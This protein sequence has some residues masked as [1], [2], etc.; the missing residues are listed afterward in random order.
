[1]H[2]N[3]DS[4]GFMCCCWNS[5][6]Q[7]LITHGCGALT[8]ISDPCWSLEEYVDSVRLRLNCAGLCEPVPCAA[9]QPRS[10]DTG[11]AHATCCALGE[12]TRGH[13]A[14]TAQEHA[15]AQS[16]DCTS[17]FFVPGLNLGT[18][19][20][21]ADVFTS[22][23]GNSYTALDISIC[24]QHAQQAG[25]DSSQSRL[26]A[27]LAHCGPHLPFAR[28][29]IRTISCV[30]ETKWQIRIG[31]VSLRDFFE[32]FEFLVC[33]KFNDTQCG[34]T[35]AF[36]VAPHNSIANVVVFVTIHD[37]KKITK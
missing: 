12:A 1:M 5:V 33:S 19:L 4:W 2:E 17:D 26:G 3:A 31:F 13:N 36:A 14:V 37:N 28:D 29:Q 16:W 8:R 32:R 30:F 18:D 25:S 23:L 34:C 24:S 21:P 11:A 35:C 15:A 9:C 7:R 6:K 10:L 22:N 20:R 27:K